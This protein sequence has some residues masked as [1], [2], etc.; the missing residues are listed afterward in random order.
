MF[1]KIKKRKRIKC[2]K[3]LIESYEKTLKDL[4]SSLWDM[5]H[6][7]PEHPI[8]DE[9]FVQLLGHGS[10]EEL[11]AHYEKLI[12]NIQEHKNKLEEELWDL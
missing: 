12:K 5:D 11:K 8:F 6:D 4:K 2:L 3:Y 9:W 7:D 10:K 1:E